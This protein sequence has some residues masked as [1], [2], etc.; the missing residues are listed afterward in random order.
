MK[1]SWR[2]HGLMVQIWMYGIDMKSWYRH[3]LM[4]QTWTHGIEYTHGI[5]S[6]SWYSVGTPESHTYKRAKGFPYAE[7]FVMN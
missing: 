5:D 3:G 7:F 4:V 1:S 6:D 2:G